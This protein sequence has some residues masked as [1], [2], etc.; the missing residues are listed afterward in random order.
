MGMTWEDTQKAFNSVLAPWWETSSLEL[1]GLKH[2]GSHIIDDIQ[3]KW[4]IDFDISDEFF[5][6]LGVIE[7]GL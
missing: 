5:P 4:E 6:S 2:V 7:G 3:K 1:S